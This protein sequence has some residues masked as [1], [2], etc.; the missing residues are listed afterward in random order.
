[1]SL[2]RFAVPAFATFAALASMCVAP[3]AQAQA[4]RPDPSPLRPTDSRTTTAPLPGTQ[5]R[6]VDENGAWERVPGCAR[7]IAAGANEVI[8]ITGCDVGQGGASAIYRWNGRAFVPHPAGGRGSAIATF[9]GTTYVVGAD[10]LLYSSINDGPWQKRGTPN[11]KPIVDVG[12]GDAGLWVVTSTPNGE[13]GNAIARA[14]PCPND[15]RLLP[16]KDFCGWEEMPGA[17]MR[18]SVAHTAWVATANRELYEFFANGGGR[19]S[20]RTGCFR[21][22][23]VGGHTVYAIAC[24]EG[25]GDGNA[26]WRWSDG[27]D[28][29]DV[30]GAGKRV[31]LDAAGNAWAITDSG[32]IWRRTHRVPP[33]RL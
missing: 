10:A 27:G 8:Y 5:P 14:T 15:G 28:W 24:E 11:G 22:V 20:K 30:K 17:A 16:E 13:G 4:H 29:Y 32:Q 9:A 1:M 19:W 6:F 12:V 25:K 23:A 2:A 18:I 33:P 7:D 26:I 31:A 3:F 21:D